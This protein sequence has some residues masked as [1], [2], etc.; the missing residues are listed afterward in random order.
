MEVGVGLSGAVNAEVEVVSEGEMDT[1]GGSDEGEGKDKSVEPQRPAGRELGIGSSMDTVLREWS[2]MEGECSQG[3]GRL[4]GSCELQELSA[5]AEL[6]PLSVVPETQVYRPSQEPSQASVRL[7]KPQTYDSDSEVDF[8][9]I[10]SAR[11]KAQLNRQMKKATS[12]SK[13]RKD[14]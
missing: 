2:S 11:K 7:A 10:L 14:K 5:S 4:V 3:S 6:F 13:H 9:Q 12:S 8:A 1:A